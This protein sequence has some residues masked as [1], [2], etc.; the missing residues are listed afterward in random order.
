MTSKRERLESALAEIRD[1]NQREAAV[2]EVLR[3]I[4][5]ERAG[6][7]AA[8]AGEIKYMDG[9]ELT[10][11]QWRAVIGG[12]ETEVSSSVTRDLLREAM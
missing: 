11:E 5:R 6:L 12:L 9:A 1:L 4:R 10:P 2:F 3:E 7:D 8:I